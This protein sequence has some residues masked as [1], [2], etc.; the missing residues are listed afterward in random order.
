MPGELG[1]QDVRIT[2][3]ADE[4][5]VEVMSDA[6]GELTHRLHLLRLPKLFLEPAAFGDV[7]RHR[8]DILLVTDGRSAKTDL[9]LAF[10]PFTARKVTVETFRRCGR[11]AADLLPSNAPTIEIRRW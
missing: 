10:L 3:N 8:K 11:R 7:T 1:S 5:I 6:A 9:D 2:D 4:L